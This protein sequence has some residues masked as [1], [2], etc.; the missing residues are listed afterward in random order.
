[1]IA[2]TG[3]AGKTG[4]AVA[5]RLAEE[6]VGVRGIVRRAPGP[7]EVVAD[8]RDADALALALEGADVLYHIPP[9]LLPDEVAVTAAVIEA[10]QRAGVPRV[11]YHSVMRP[12]LEAMPHHWAKLRSEEMLWASPL[13]VTVLQP[14]VYADNFRR[15]TSGAPLQVPYSVD[16]RFSFVTLD[17]VARAARTVLLEPGHGGATYELAGPERLSIRDVATLLGVEARRISIEEWSR[18]NPAVV[19]YAF[20]ALAGMFEWYDAHGLEG[21]PTVLE[22]LVGGRLR[23]L[24]EEL[25]DRRPG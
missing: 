10:A 11:V 4:R 2:L 7:G 24:R 20:E 22:A 12:G 3:A 19:G 25:V 21:S 17:D 16:S 5:R 9:N 6:H 14:C 18:Q 23:T 8:L 13:D 15:T 1:M